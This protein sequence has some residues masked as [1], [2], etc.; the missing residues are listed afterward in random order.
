M[1]FLAREPPRTED[2]RR[3]RS[4]RRFILGNQLY[5]LLSISR[6]VH[7]SA[8]FRS[9]QYVPHLPKAKHFYSTQL[10]YELLQVAAPIGTCE[11]AWTSLTT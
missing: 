4:L 11:G 1:L 8:T 3:L 10:F 6:I 2:L 7:Q 9:F 5:S